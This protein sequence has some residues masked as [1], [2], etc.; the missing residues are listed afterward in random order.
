VVVTAGALVG[1]A[2]SDVV[3][4]GHE[5]VVEVELARCTDLPAVLEID[6]M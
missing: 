5:D 2:V 3:G 1:S 6:F 4:L